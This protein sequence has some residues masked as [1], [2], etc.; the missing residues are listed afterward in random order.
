MAFETNFSDF[1]GIFVLSLRE[2]ISESGSGSARI[3]IM[4]GLLNTGTFPS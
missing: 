4:E 1:V 2:I 3:S